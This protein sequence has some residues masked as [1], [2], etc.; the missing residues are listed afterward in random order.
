MMNLGHI[1]RGTKMSI[2]EDI[3]NRVVGDEYEA[4][5]RHVESERTFLVLS[6]GLY[7]NFGSI[8]PGSTLRLSFIS[9]PNTY[10]FTGRALEKQR[11]NGLVLIEQLT[12]IETFSSRQYDRDELRLHVMVYGLPEAQIGGTVF[13]KPYSHPD[14]SDVTYDISVGGVCV[15]SNTMLKTAHDPYYLV[16]FSLSDKDRFLLPAKLVRR[17]NC[18]RTKIGRYDYGFQFIFEKIPEEKG[19]LSRSILN[20]KLS[21]R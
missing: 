17:I 15:I 19:R 6:P 13:I 1:E 11:T 5:F 7:N 10:T 14:L 9:E 18:P 2:F 21:A 4:V 20:K 8:R 12:G 3:Q 16:E